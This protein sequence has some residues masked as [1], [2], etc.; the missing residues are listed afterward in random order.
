MKPLT[1]KEQ[2]QPRTTL[3]RS[4][5]KLLNTGYKSELYFWA[6]LFKTNDVVS[7]RIVKTLIIK[8]GLYVNIFAEKLWVAFAFAKATHIFSAKILWIG[9]C[10]H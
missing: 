7:L 10:T 5:E 9:Y 1:H 4:L 8:Y 3:E 6:Q 2:L